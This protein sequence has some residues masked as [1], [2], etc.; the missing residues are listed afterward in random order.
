MLQWYVFH[1][2]IHNEAS[3]YHI[4]S[5]LG[6]CTVNA[7]L[8]NAFKVCF[9]GTPKDVVESLALRGHFLRNLQDD[10]ARNFVVGL[11]HHEPTNAKAIEANYQFL[12]E[13]TATFATKPIVPARGVWKA[14]CVHC[15]LA[16]TKP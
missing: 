9:D 3:G 12:L 2:G 11:Q 5:Q 7:Q 14:A 13:S 15:C 1:N 10:V 4:T 16:S 6:Q 8:T